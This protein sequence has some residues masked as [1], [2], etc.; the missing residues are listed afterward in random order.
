MQNA[1]SKDIAEFYENWVRKE[2]EQSS[3]EKESPNKKGFEKE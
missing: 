1:S 2:P 3:Y